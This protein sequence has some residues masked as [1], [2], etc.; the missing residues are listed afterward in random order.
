MK[1]RRYQTAGHRGGEILQLAAGQRHG[2]GLVVQFDGVA[3]RNEAEALVGLEL[4]VERCQLDELPP[5]EFYR[6]DLLGYDV[7]TES[8]YSLGK[9]S[10]FMETGAHDV[11]VVHGDRERL[12]PFAQDAIVLAVE[13]EDRRITVEWEPDY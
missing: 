7:V 10:D 8:G 4:N 9:L 12:I 1:Y 13:T 3:D 2:K 6:I 11:M 5:G